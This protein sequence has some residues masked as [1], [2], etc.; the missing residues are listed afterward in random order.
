MTIKHLVLPGGGTA[1]MCLVGALQKLHDANIWNIDDIQAIYSVSAG[2]M[3]ALLVALKFSWD[4]I[5]DYLVKRPWSDVYNVNLANIFDIFMKKGFY[6]PEFFITF[7]KPFFDSKDIN[8]NITMLEL[9]TI[10]GVDIHFCTTEMSSL[11]MLSSS[12]ILF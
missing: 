7:F 3:I 10:T 9:Y 11:T 5:V 8:M 4:T 1:G 6:G 2:S 12:L